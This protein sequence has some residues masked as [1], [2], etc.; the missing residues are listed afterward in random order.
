MDREHEVDV[1]SVFLVVAALFREEERPRGAASGREI[2]GDL[3]EGL[4]VGRRA[5]GNQNSRDESRKGLHGAASIRPW[6]V[7]THALRHAQV[8]P[9]SAPRV[10]LRHAQGRPPTRNKRAGTAVLRSVSFAYCARRLGYAELPSSASRQ[11]RALA[12]VAIKGLLRRRPSRVSSVPGSHN[13]RIA[14]TVIAAM[15]TCG[16]QLMGSN[17]AALDGWRPALSVPKGDW[18]SPMFSRLT[19][20]PMFAVAQLQEIR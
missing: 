16:P 11:P 20:L 12:G 19:L 18:V 17:P 9:S 1:Q 14:A 13:I 8:R 2:D 6:T 3:L 15:R 7:P 4:R 5:A 10:A